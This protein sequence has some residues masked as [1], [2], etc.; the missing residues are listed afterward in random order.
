MNADHLKGN[1]QTMKTLGSKELS[2][3]ATK[4]LKIQPKGV[5]QFKS[6]DL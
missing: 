6:P 4:E 2:K 5:Q 1:L 3:T